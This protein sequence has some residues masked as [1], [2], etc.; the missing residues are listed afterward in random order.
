M[1]IIKLSCPLCGE[2]DLDAGQIRLQLWRDPAQNNYRFE[3]PACRTTVV[4]PVT[5]RMLLVLRNQGV[6]R[7]GRRSTR[8]DSPCVR[9]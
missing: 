2:V 7:R 1:A 4:K 5:A 3:C 9:P 6:K 8:S